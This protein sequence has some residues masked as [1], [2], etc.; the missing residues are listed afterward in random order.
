VLTVI[1]GTIV[2]P[3]KDNLTCPG[4]TMTLRLEFARAMPGCRSTVRPVAKARGGSPRRNVAVVV[5]RRSA[6]R[7]DARRTPVW[8]R[9]AGPGLQ[10]VHGF[11]SSEKA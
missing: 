3:P 7:D 8:Q 5:G 2:A 11:T 6:G 4:I 1:A 10:K 9:R